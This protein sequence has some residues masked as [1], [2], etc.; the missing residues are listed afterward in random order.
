MLVSGK[1]PIFMSM[2]ELEMLL[3]SRYNEPWRHYHNW[4][5]VTRMLEEFEQVRHM[6]INA[7]AVEW[8][9]M[10]HD[11]VYEPTANNNEE[12]SA[13]LAEAWLE[14][15]L[16]PDTVREVSRLIRL[17]QHHDPHPED[18]NGCLICDCDLAVMGWEWEEF[19]KFGEAI[20]REYNFVSDE[21]FREHR[22]M[23][24]KSFVRRPRIFQTEYFHE[25]YDEQARDNL[26]HTIAVLS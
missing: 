8:A 4:G 24:M 3:R 25:K 9:I 17:T 2:N 16:P 5:H 20:R 11:V 10:F 1:G 22:R 12:R 13:Q 23:F 18:M 6:A 19:Q 26:H 21:E 14:D 7:E 15:M